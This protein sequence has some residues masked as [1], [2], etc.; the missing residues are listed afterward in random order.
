[1]MSTNLS[2]QESKLLNEALF[3]KLSSTDPIMQKE[4]VD[5]VNDFTRT[6]MREDGFFRRIMP[7]VPISNDELD[8]QVS[9]DKPVKVVDKEP[10]SPAAVSIPFATLPTNVYIRGNRYLVHMDRIV[11]PRFTKDV[12]ELRTWVMDIRQVLSDNAIKDM[13]SEEDSKFMTAVHAAIGTSTSDTNATSGKP[14]WATAANVNRDNLWEAMKVMPGLPSGLET[15]TILINSV[16]IKDIA[17]LDRTEIGGDLSEDI[18]RNGWSE[19]NFMG[20][21]WIVT[22]KGAGQ[23]TTDYVKDGN[24]YMFSDPKFIGKHYQLEDTTMYIRREAYMLEFF[25]YQTS[26]ATLGHTGGLAGYTFT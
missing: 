14:Q 24:M 19:Q 20:V 8:R 23:S 6:K 9:T 18:M 5:A 21:R 12:D 13:L 3:E 25:A 26:G 16:T 2:Q 15:H 1:M 17:K 22:I 4:A 11:T 7:P 10:G